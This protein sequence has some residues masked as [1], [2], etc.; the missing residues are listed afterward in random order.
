MI[1]CS[2]GI[3][4]FQP[5]WLAW[6]IALLPAAAWRQL[7][8]SCWP[9]VATEYAQER[10]PDIANRILLCTHTPF[11]FQIEPLPG[12]ILVAMLIRAMAWTASLYGCHKIGRGTVL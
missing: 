9:A 2:T 12:S 11:D 7:A 8:D 4:A 10:L 3:P 1:T 5:R 6:N